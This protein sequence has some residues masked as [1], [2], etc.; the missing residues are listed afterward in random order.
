[1]ISI[2]N[3]R[4]GSSGRRLIAVRSNERAAASLGVSIFGAKLYAFSLGAAIAGLA[5]VFLGYQ[6]TSVEL[7]P[8]TTLASINSVL[9]A[10]IG[11]IGHVVGSIFSFVLA[12]GGLGARP[13]LSLGDVN[14]W[15]ETYSGVLLIVTLLLNPNGLAVSEQNR[16]MWEKISGRLRRRLFVK[17]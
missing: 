11:G 4:R 1:A 9:L 2:A 12:P 3:L 15:I 16:V 7:A 14:R 13:F 8:F 10:T 17:R 6:S 5:G